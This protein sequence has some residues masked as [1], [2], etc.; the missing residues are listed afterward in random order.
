[1]SFKILKLVHVSIFSKD[2]KKVENFY[3]KLL[4]LKIV[5]KFKNEKNEVYGF[6]LKSGGGTLIEFFKTTKKKLGKGRINHICLLTNSIKDASIFLTKNK[7]KYE[8]LISKKDKTKHIKIKDF[9]NNI[10][11]FHEIKDRRSKISKYYN[12]KK[13]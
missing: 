1:M 3:V 5:F 9:E 8:K 11:E 13:L 10:I 4:K 2:L 7:I 12:E 6:F